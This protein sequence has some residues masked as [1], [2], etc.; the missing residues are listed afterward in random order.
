MSYERYCTT[1]GKH[2]HCR[3]ERHAIAGSSHSSLRLFCPECGKAL[4]SVYN[5][6]LRIERTS[7]PPRG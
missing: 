1:C 7:P 4:G 5:D 2:V 3:E 6:A